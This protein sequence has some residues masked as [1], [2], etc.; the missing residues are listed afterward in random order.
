MP[1]FE[2]QESTNTESD[3]IV[4]LGSI[5]F[6]TKT[7][8]YVYNSESDTKYDTQSNMLGSSNY[9]PTIVS[10]KIGSLN[11]KLISQST[12]GQKATYKDQIGRYLTYVF[13]LELVGDSTAK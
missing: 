10:S 2:I 8:N 1:K 13:G 7:A 5:S 9:M 4:N 3:Y 12:D 6:D 11:I